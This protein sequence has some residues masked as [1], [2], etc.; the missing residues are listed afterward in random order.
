M[1]HI[2]KKKRTKH[3]SHLSHIV[4]ET[5]MF[6]YS[7]FSLDLCFNTYYYLFIW[8][9]CISVAA[10]RTFTAASRSLAVACKHLA[11]A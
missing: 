4:I 8:L 7:F 9:H 10:H 2:K 3:N 1:A 11:V 5:I 6:L